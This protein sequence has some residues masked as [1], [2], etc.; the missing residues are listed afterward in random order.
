[1]DYEDEIREHRLTP[2]GLQAIE[3]GSI[4]DDE[5]LFFMRCIQS[6]EALE[7]PDRT[8]EEL[9]EFMDWYHQVQTDFMLIEMIIRGDIFIKEKVAP[10]EFTFA[11]SPQGTTRA[12]EEARRRGE[13]IPDWAEQ[14]PS[15]D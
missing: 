12:I 11:A 6:A 4:K 3:D 5:M 7:L 2:Q 15:L 8:E 13:E 10:G 9:Q 14:L 1:M